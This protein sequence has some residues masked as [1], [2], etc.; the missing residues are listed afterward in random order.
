MSKYKIV[1]ELGRG[2]F[3][4]AYRA[5]NRLGAEFALKRVGDGDAAMKEAKKVLEVGEHENVV[6][7]YEITE[8][9]DGHMGQLY[10]VMD[11]VDGETLEDYL[12]RSG[13]LDAE[14]W[15]TLLVPILN[16][17]HHIHHSLVHRDLKPANIVLEKGAGLPS[18][19]IIDFGLA[20]KHGANPT[21]LGGTRYYAPPEWEK[22]GLIGS[23]SDVYSLAAISYHALY[24]GPPWERRE[25]QTDLREDGDTFRL[26]IAKGLEEMPED[27]PQ[28]IWEWIIAM[29]RPPAE[30]S[31]PLG[32]GSSSSPD[33]PDTRL[34]KPSTVATLRRE[35]EEDYKLPEGCVVLRR[36]SGKVAGGG[37]A[38]KKLRNDSSPGYYYDEDWTS[39]DLSESTLSALSED[40]GERY[41]L[42][43]GCVQFCNPNKTGP[44]GE[45]LYSMNTKIATMWDAYEA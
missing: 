41:G 19:T 30:E 33:G 26:A 13:C 39:S 45:R 23:W 11:Y 10:I 40:I 18:P 2:G 29:A 6:R 28:S 5:T 25:M 44:V 42:T 31:E 16:G 34:A 20:M 12:E 17:V 21:L 14:W 37:L 32:P 4:A 22:P 3:G 15:W 7:V 24:G 43:K 8:E 27:R 38:T 36:R 35:I 1:E 9:V